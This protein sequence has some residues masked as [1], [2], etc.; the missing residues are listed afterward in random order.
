MIWQVSPK[1]GRI[2]SLTQQLR[3]AQLEL[4]IL[5]RTH[6]L[7]SRVCFHRNLS[8]SPTHSFTLIKMLIGVT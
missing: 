3:C 6:F 1:T 7:T 2:V 8:G 5:P 4:H